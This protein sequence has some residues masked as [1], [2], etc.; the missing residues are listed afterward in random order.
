MSTRSLEDLNLASIAK[1][2]FEAAVPFTAELAGWRGIAEWIFRPEKVTKVTLPVRMDDGYIHTFLGY[3]VLHDTIRGPGK[4]GFRFHPAVDE[5]EVTALATWMTWKCAITDIP[6]GGAK[7]GVQCDPHTLSDGEKERITR[8]YIAALGDAIGPHSDIPAPDLY[9]D[10]RTMA[11]AYDTYTMMHSGSNNLG[12]V[13]GKPV[14]LG[15]SLGRDTATAQGT[16]FA[17]ERMLEV[18]AIPEL[19]SVDGAEVA[20]QGFGNAGRNAAKLFRAAGAKIVAV[21]DTKGGI[22]SPDG[23][24]IAAVEQLKDE[25]GSVIDLPGSKPLNPLEVLEVPCDILIP[26]AMENQI[27]AA[28]AERVR[29][30]VIAE[31]ANGPTTPEADAILGEQGISVI[32][33]VLAAAGGVVVSYF[34]WVQ[35][36]ANETWTA[37]EVHDR[38]REKMY[39][40]TDAVVTTRAALIENLETYQEAWSKAQPRWPRPER[41]TLRTAAHVVALGRCRLAAEHRGIWP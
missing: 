3:R 6:F 33:D 19:S 5:D 39:R 32:P 29:A 17:V 22:Y 21:S 26:A 8:R 10:A 23:L 36:L 4:G 37:A 9:T 20:I 16:L 28:N 18:H 14:G 35:N 41:P 31:S 15:G 1:Q 27:T 38:L 24:D 40:A 13:T 25:T 12:V 11:W 30:K 34:E 7:G 2:Q